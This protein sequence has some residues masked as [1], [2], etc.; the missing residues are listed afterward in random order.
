MRSKGSGGPAGECLQT[1]LQKTYKT[2]IITAYT[3]SVRGAIVRQFERHESLFR[4]AYLAQ[5]VPQ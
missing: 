2:Y 4:E 3:R 5:V 1:S